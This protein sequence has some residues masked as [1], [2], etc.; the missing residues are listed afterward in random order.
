VEAILLHIPS[1]YVGENATQR[2]KKAGRS[3]NESRK[4]TVD[5]RTTDRL[6]PHG[7][8]SPEAL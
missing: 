5:N 2:L 7:P 8:R 3:N 4:S 1:F 6:Y